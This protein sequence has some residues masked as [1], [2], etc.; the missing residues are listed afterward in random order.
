M[1]LID[2]D[3]L[4]NT[5]ISTPKILVLLA[6]Y[7]GM[8]YLDEQITSILNQVFVNVTIMVSV[9]VSSD[10]SEQWLTQLALQDSRV[11]LLPHGEKFGGAARNFFRLICDTNINNYDYI[12][13]ADQDDYWYPDKLS[14]AVII[15]TKYYDAYS[16]NVLSFW[17]NGR[18]RL[19]DKAQP[20]RRWDFIF[21]AAGPGCTYVMTKKLMLAIKGCIQNNWDKVQAIHLHDWFCYAYARTHH[22]HWFIDPK[23]SMRYRQHTHNQIGANYGINAYY[24]RFK[25]IKSGWWFNQASLIAEVVGIDDWH[26]KKQNSGLTKRQLLRLA[27]Q[28]THCRRRYQDRIFFLLMCLLMATIG[29][30]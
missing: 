18:E 21:E 20:Q 4:A 25:L 5:T 14:K 13:F 3:L 17:P 7:N 10:G 28:A 26:F 12:S 9:D 24:R 22:Y 6:V 23:P 1:D 27:C 29:Y 15:L 11:Q 19:I 30:R 16:S 2:D 8:Q